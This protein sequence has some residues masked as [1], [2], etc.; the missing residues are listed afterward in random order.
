MKKNREKVHSNMFKHLIMSKVIISIFPKRPMGSP[1]RPARNSWRKEEKQNKTKQSLPKTIWGTQI[2]VKWDQNLSLHDQQ[3]K[4][5]NL[6]VHLPSIRCTS[7][8]QNKVTRQNKVKS[9]KVTAKTDS[10]MFQSMFQLLLEVVPLP[11]TC[12]TDVARRTSG[13]VRPSRLRRELRSHRT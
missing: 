7:A 6:Q 5:S 13:P 10:N 3:V 12:P 8:W 1:A 9:G 11:G 4:Q 2:R